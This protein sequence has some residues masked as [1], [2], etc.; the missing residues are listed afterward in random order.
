MTA[1]QII[2]NRA[3]SIC[4]G[5]RQQHFR[6]RAELTVNQLMASSERQLNTLE[7]ISQTQEQLRAVADN[8]ID[9]LEIGRQKIAAD[10][11]QLKQ[12]HLSMNS[13]VLRNLQHIRQQ[14]DTIIAGNGQLISKTEQIQQ[15]LDST[16]EQI[17]EQ[18]AVQSAHHREILSDLAQLGVQAEDVSSKLE[19]STTLVE[20]SHRSMIE[21]QLDAIENLK[22]IN[23]T[24]NFILS[25]V[26]SFRGAV[27]A[28]LEWIRFVTDAN[29]SR[30][31][32]LAAHIVY[33]LVALS[34]F[35]L[36]RVMK[37][38][39]YLLVTIILSNA[40]AEL[41]FNCGFGYAGLSAVLLAAA[42][43]ASFIAWC[44]AI[45]FNNSP[46]AEPIAQS[47]LCDNHC[48]YRNDIK[49]VIAALEQISADFTRRMSSCEEKDKVEDERV[50]CSTPIRHLPELGFEHSGNQKQ[51]SGFPLDCTPPPIR[52]HLLPLP[53]TP[54]NPPPTPLVSR[55]PLVVDS[56]IWQLDMNDVSL[57]GSP[58]N[59]A[60]FS[61]TPRTARQK[62][63]RTSSL[64]RSFSRPLC[65]AVTKSGQSCKLPSQEGSSLCHR[66][67][68]E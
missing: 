62:K 57:S 49:Y 29:N 27:E 18:A 44:S 50:T 31:A 39:S 53:A 32:V 55:A 59:S 14:R 25:L 48:L 6:A 13:Q 9:Q 58:A 63:C 36:L 47:A 65:T 30:V 68:L 60:S 15:K 2:S 46:T 61:T 45:R 1:L 66:H 16:S 33:A 7:T 11:Q 4:Y 19:A 51:A 26:N 34:L 64:S 41:L 54:P 22:Q 24:V 17:S 10:Q 56:E 8:T 37:C 3:R 40:S 38:I 5:V 43:T 67:Q 28:K 21:H 52:R 23:D 35:S 20:N 42:L 12:A